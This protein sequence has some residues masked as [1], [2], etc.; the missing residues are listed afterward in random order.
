MERNQIGTRSE[1]CDLKRAEE[2]G[3]EVVE[4]DGGEEIERWRN[5]RSLRAV[6]FF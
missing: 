5:K 3:E 4:G 1:S 2:R 6:G